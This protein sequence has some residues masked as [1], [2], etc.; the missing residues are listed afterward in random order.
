MKKALIFIF[1]FLFTLSSYSQILPS[2]QASHYKSSTGAIQGVSA[3]FTSCDAIRHIG[4]TQAQVDAEYLGINLEGLVTSSSGI[5]LFTVPFSGTFTITAIGATGGNEGEPTVEVGH[6]A[7]ITGEFNLT[8]GEVIKIL[9][10]QHGWKASCRPGWGGGG[11]T[12]VTKNDNSP[13]VVAGGCGGP[14]LKP[15]GV[16]THSYQNASLTTTGNRGTGNNQAAA[17]NGAGGSGG[18]GG[19]GAGLLGN[20]DVGNNSRSNPCAGVGNHTVP[21][22]FVNG[23]VG[24]GF[25]GGF[26]GGGGVTNTYGG[27]GG[28]YS[29][30]G[31]AKSGSPY[32]GGG[33]ASFNGG[34]NQVNILDTNDD[35]TEADGKVIISW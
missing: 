34:A 13:L 35:F 19:S 18:N 3:T 14:H 5:Q 8:Q 1:F 29:G 22:A 11:G 15:W 10:G 7:K 33:G 16:G 28:G 27:G 17:T 2:H 21:Q 23:G 32:C 6:P 25:G 4:P 20:G 30:G 24:D 26:G 31:G 12:F 9:V